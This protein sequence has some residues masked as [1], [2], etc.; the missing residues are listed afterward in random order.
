LLGMG[1]RQL[2]EVPD[3]SVFDGLRDADRDHDRRITTGELREYAASVLPRLTAQFPE[4]TQRA[5]ESPRSDRSQAASVPEPSLRADTAS[6]PLV[7]LPGGEEGGSRD[8]G[9]R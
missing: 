5:G 4:L 9:R 6:F 1:E 8:R 3:P 2:Q 7:V